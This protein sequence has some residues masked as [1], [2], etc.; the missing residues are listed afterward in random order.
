MAASNKTTTSTSKDD[1]TGTNLTIPVEVEDRNIHHM[2]RTLADKDYPEIRAIGP[3]TAN[4]HIRTWLQQGYTL[5]QVVPLGKDKV[6]GVFVV[7]ILY[8]LVLQ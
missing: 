8:I 6:E 3:D 1:L 4:A 7:E 2:V 5:H